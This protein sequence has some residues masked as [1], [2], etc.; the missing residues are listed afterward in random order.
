MVRSSPKRTL[1][2]ACGN[3]NNVYYN[4]FESGSMDKGDQSMDFKIAR[5]IGRGLCIAWFSREKSG[6]FLMDGLA[7][8]G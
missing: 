3:G 1:R 7:A 8:G 4:G 6:N 2:F 5:W